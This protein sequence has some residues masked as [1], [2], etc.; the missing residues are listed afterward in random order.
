MTPELSVIFV[1]WNGGEL[2]RR[3]VESVE[4]FAPSAPFEIIVVDNASTDGSREWLR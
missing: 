2:L 3:A 4:R 1:N